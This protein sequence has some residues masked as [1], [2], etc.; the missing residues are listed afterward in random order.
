M[1]DATPGWTADNPFSCKST[2]PFEA[3]PF[4]RIEEQH[5]LPAFIE[6][7]AQHRAEVQRIAVDDAAPSFANTVEAMER[8]GALL[9]R[10][11]SV[12]FNLTGSTT[13]EALQRIQ[14]EVAPKLAAHSDAIWLDPALFA[15]VQ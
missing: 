1:T 13:T 7:M 6:G 4:D 3:P 5:F 12:F 14:A 11:A 8:A 2:L 10:T 9:G 15:R